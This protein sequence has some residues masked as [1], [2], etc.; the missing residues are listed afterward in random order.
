MA[1]LYGLGVGQAT[2]YVEKKDFVAASSG[3]LFA[4]GVGSAIGPSVAGLVVGA[5][6]PNGLFLFL[7][8]VNALLGL[9]VIW[10]ILIRRAKSATRA[11]ELRRRAVHPG[12]LWRARAR[13]P[14]R[15][16]DASPPQDRGRLTPP[17]LPAPSS[18]RGS[19]PR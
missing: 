2:D 12:H 4:W 15:A 8:G 13:S 5:T 16:D 6:G 18:S 14:R 9:F 17:P 10:R 19:S 7:G 1:P 11:V 3:L